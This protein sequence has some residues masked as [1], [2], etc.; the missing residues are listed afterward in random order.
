MKSTACIAAALVFSGFAMSGEDIKPPLAPKPPVPVSAAEKPSAPPVPPLYARAGGVAQIAQLG[1]EFTALLVAD[2]TLLANEKI[3]QA[4]TKSS[5][6]VLRF[7]ITA[8]LCQVAGGPE[9]YSGSGVLDLYNELN[10]T[11]KEIAAVSSALQKALEKIKTPADQQKEW[12][13]QADLLRKA[14]FAAKANEPVEYQNKDKN[15]AISFPK[16]W[17]RK[18]NTAGATVVA[19]SPA[20]G[21]NDLFREHAAVVVEDL[22]IDVT[23]EEYLKANVLASKHLV[24]MKILDTAPITSGTLSGHRMIYSHKL[25]AQELRV[26]SLYFV[27]KRRGY[28][29]NCIAASDQAAK[30]LPVFEGI[31]RTFKLLEAPPAPVSPSAPAHAPK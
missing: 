6:A 12:L 28:A 19:F 18:E 26:V 17:E 29:V 14:I 11:D 22:P 25:G 15:F 21:E 13:D 10:V 27:V 16:S 20:E 4:I 8:L 24:E 5:K 7:H 1:E 3:K 23:S 30:Y 9:R 2:E 31:C